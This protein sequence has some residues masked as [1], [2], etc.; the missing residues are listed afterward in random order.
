MYASIMILLGQVED[1][2]AIAGKQSRHIHVHGDYKWITYEFMGYENAKHYCSLK[3]FS[4]IW[5][6]VY[7]RGFR[8]LYVLLLF[9][10]T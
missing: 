3:Q 10:S 7:K 2:R 1:R 9:F 8:L 5:V 6:S 4:L